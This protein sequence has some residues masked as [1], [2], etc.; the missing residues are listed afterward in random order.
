VATQLRYGGENDKDFIAEFL[1]DPKVKELLKSVNI[2]Q[3]YERKIS[4]VFF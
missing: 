4:L 2:W 3:S 1:L